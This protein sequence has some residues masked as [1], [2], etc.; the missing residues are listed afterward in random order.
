MVA[1]ETE[2]QMEA[3][4][5]QE[6]NRDQTTTNNLSQE[7]TAD[8]EIME[9]STIPTAVAASDQEAVA[10]VVEAAADSDPAAVEAVASIV[11]DNFQI[12]NYSKNNV[13][14]NFSNNEYFCRIFCAGSRC[15][16]D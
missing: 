1:S 3:S 16:C 2:I 11:V 4:V 5:I 6:I 14:K 13:K 12:N 15:F 9:V 7:M 10:S 8:L